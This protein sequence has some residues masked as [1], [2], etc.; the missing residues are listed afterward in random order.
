MARATATKTATALKTPEE[1][2]RQ[3]F[4]SLRS[5]LA[6]AQRSVENAQ[7][8]LATVPRELQAQ[9]RNKALEAINAYVEAVRGAIGQA[10]AGFRIEQGVREYV[11]KIQN[12]TEDTQKELTD[13]VK[14]YADSLK[15]VPEKTRKTIDAAYAEYVEGLREYIAEIDWDDLEPQSMAALAQNMLAVAMYTSAA[16]NR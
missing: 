8:E 11:G 9:A 1:L 15:K 5:A 14:T 16:T 13:A 2:T 3:Y 7:R 4:E 6:E 12:T 10:D